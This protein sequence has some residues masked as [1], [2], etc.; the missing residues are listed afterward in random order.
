[1]CEDVVSASSSQ[2]EYRL[3]LASVTGYR[4]KELLL[5]CNLSAY[6][7][8]AVLLLARQKLL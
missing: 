3:L 6:N 7:Y 8:L 4:V 1:M 2:V 5:E